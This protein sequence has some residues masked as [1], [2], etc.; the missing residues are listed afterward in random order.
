MQNLP[1]GDEAAEFSEVL[2][3]FY[4]L[5]YEGQDEQPPAILKMFEN[6]K[7]V[8]EKLKVNK[9]IKS[10]GHHAAHDENVP[11]GY[12]DE[13]DVN[14]TCEEFPV[15]VNGFPHR[16]S[17]DMR[18]GFPHRDSLALRHGKQYDLNGLQFSNAVNPVLIIS[19][20]EL[21]E[22]SDGELNE[23]EDDDDSGIQNGLSEGTCTTVATLD[24]THALTKQI[25]DLMS[26]KS[27]RNF[28]GIEHRAW[29]GESGVSLAFQG[30]L[31]PTGGQ[32]LL[33]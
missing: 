24:E 4:T 12:S 20:D 16:D 19:P 7:K 32:N 33:N 8:P 1:D 13:C 11:N 9:E 21:K 10:K 6:E 15:K 27:N 5:V 17:M 25:G 23:G 31:V 28:W 29:W 2:K 22:E 18:A 26:Y 3:A 30:Q 14:G